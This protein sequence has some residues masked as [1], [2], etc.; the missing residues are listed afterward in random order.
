MEAMTPAAN[1]YARLSEEARDKHRER[2]RLRKQKDRESRIQAMIF[3]V[4]E[5]REGAYQSVEVQGL[6]P[7]VAHSL[8]KLLKKEIRD[9][10]ERRIKSGQ[11]PV[12]GIENDVVFEFGN[13]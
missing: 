10:V 3:E 8:V 13:V 1:K 6:D 4:R 9:E 2:T 11:N 12:F 5:I 7:E